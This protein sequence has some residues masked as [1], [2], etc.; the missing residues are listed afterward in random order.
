[1]HKTS[2]P[3]LLARMIRT[4]PVNQLSDTGSGDHLRRTITLFQLTMLGVGILAAS[5]PARRA[6]AVDPMTLL[7]E[8]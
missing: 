6:L 7:R 5:I 8:E 2:T 4:K 3:S 1:M